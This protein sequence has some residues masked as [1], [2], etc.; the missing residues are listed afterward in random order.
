MK[1]RTSP[2]GKTKTRVFN[3]RLDQPTMDTILNMS[4]AERRTMT[5]MVQVLIAEAIEH[6]EQMELAN[7][8]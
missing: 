1:K 6:R 2:N 8:R 4:E 5:N 7:A 3:V